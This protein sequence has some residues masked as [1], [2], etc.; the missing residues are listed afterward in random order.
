MRCPKNVR[1]TEAVVS[2]SGSQGLLVRVGRRRWRTERSF[3]LIWSNRMP[4]LP[5]AM[6]VRAWIL[7]AAPDPFPS[8]RSGAAG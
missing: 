6:A 8:R 3:Y 1:F 7:D 2:G 5:Q 4:V